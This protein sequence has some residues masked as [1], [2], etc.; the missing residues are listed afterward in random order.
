MLFPFAEP[1]LID[2]GVIRTVRDVV[3]RHRPWTMQLTGPAAF[4]DA[5]YAAVAPPDAPIALQNDLAAAFPSLPIYGGSI[6]VF[7]P[8]VTIA[9]L[10]RGSDPSDLE[11]ASGWRDLPSTSPA[12]GVELIV[13]GPSGRWSVRHR[14][15][16]GA[17]P[18]PS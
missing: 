14:F 8:H 10:G 7:V 11:A 1:H 12:T 6:D 17:S 2:A 9:E 13:C 15:P 5:L 18:A 16:L 3:A 4:P